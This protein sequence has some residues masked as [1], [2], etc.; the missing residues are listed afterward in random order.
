MKLSYVVLLSDDIPAAMRFWRDVMELQLV[1]SDET[2]GYAAFDTGNAGV[3]LAIYSRSGLATL[4]GE[5]TPAAVGRQVYL[6]FPVEDVD[7]TYAKLVER[8]AKVLVKPRDVAGQ[9]SRLAHFISPDEHVIEI[10]GPMRGTT[11]SNV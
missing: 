10:F 7:A 2:I 11:A 1:Y 8:G 5:T 9:Q 4:L 3:T 6:A